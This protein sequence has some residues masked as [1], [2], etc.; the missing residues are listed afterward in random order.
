MMVLRMGTEGLSRFAVFPGPHA[1]S[2]FFN[3]I[4]RLP[5]LIV[6]TARHTAHFFGGGNGGILAL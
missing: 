1:H 4:G 3:Q 6:V 5:W 2:K